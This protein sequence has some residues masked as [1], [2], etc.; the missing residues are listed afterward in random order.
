MN[1]KQS[2]V[3]K[4]PAINLARTISTHH[5]RN[6]LATAHANLY[7]KHMDT[8]FTIPPS[9]GAEFR[10]NNEGNIIISQG[11]NDAILLT[12][13]EAEQTIS[14]LRQLLLK[15]NQES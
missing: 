2:A 12:P 3:R 1:N 10:I 15:L 7:S 14:I 5:I 6:N 8:T 4:H 13:Q 9:L 11:E